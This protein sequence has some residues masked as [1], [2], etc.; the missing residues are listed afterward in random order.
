MEMRNLCRIYGLAT[1]LLASVFCG[2]WCPPAEGAVMERAEGLLCWNGDP[3][4]PI[5]SAGNAFCNALDVSSADIVS[6]DEN[7]LLIAVL[8]DTIRMKDNSMT[9]QAV[10]YFEE[11]KADGTMYYWYDEN[12]KTR[13]SFKKGN[14]PGAMNDA[15]Y[16]VKCALGKV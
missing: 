1:I 3:N 2:P 4:Y 11:S 13:L 15:Y 14:P 5:W 7:I 16:V 6:E 12:K 10:I 9:G 8:D